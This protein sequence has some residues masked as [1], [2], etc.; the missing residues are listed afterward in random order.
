MRQ[1]LTNQIFFSHFWKE[2]PLL[3]ASFPSQ[4]T[5][6][7]YN[8]MVILGFRK[9]LT[10]DDLWHLPVE[11]KA[12]SIFSK[13]RRFINGH[14]EDESKNKPTYENEKSN[15]IERDL[16]L[17]VNIMIP[18]IK[19]FWP[20]LT[21]CMVIKL[22]ST[23][24]T[25]IQPILFDALL[26]FM[27]SDQYSWRGYFLAFS[28]AF[29]SLAGSLL[30]GQYEFLINITSMRMRSAIITIIY[31]KVSSNHENGRNFVHSTTF[32]CFCIPLLEPQ[33]IK[34]RSKK[35]YHWRNS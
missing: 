5:F 10:Q 6:W 11:F 30:N 23:I 27:A 3:G 12:K 14:I 33:I 34:F 19:A 1:I 26:T 24:M 21:T 17:K 16:N 15:Q 18:L 28:I 20:H 8:Q 35:L 32:Q 29:V 9:T 25:S 7:W 22:I 4:L 2:C 31:R 13:F